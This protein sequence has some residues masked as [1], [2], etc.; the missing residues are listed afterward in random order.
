VA[1]PVF[2]LTSTQGDRTGGPECI[3][4]LTDAIIRRGFEAYIVP[5]RNFRGRTPDPEYSMY[6]YKL[7]DRV[8][9]GRNSILLSAE[10]SPIESFRDFRAVPPERTWMWW[11]SVHNNP[12]PRARYFRGSGTCCD[13]SAPISGQPRDQLTRSQRHLTKH[14][15]LPYANANTIPLVKESWNRRGPKSPLGGSLKAFAI[16][17]GSLLYNRHTIESD[18]GFIA[19]SV[20]GQG[21]CQSVL[22]KEALP[23]TDYL[24]RP[25]IQSVKKEKNLVLY[26][27]AKGYSMAPRLQELLPNVRFEPIQKMS[28]L[29]VCESLA[30]ATMYVELGVPPG[31]DRLPRESVH[32]GTPVALLCRG[33]AYCWDDFPLPTDYRIAFQDG[34]EQEMATSIAKILSDPDAALSDQSQF[35]IWITGDIDRYEAEVDRWVA[36]VIDRM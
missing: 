11:L 16:E 9:R 13:F 36:A 3:H 24:R 19:Q 14:R 35:A 4:Q 10:V 17:Y 22:G 31:R 7:A 15:V 20:Y 6:Q 33:S 27:G 34:W 18:I 8:L 5:L 28:Y 32:F 21:F 23:V 1:N 2:Y 30:R 12:D 25:S 26:N 29:Q